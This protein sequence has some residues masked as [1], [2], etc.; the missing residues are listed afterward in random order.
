MQEKDIANTFAKLEEHLFFARNQY[1]RRA[2]ICSPLRA[3]TALG[4]YKNMYKA[5]EYMLYTAR[6]MKYTPYAPH[7][8]IPMLLNDIFPEERVLALDFGLRLLELCETLFVCGG[9]ISDGMKGEISHAAKKG[10][11]ILVFNAHVC[12]E[13]KQI[14]SD[15]GG[16]AQSVQLNVSHSY[17]GNPVSRTGR[18]KVSG[19][20]WGG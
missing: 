19:H 1:H 5:R 10:L 13:V 15:A 17:L 18:G 2:Y 11:K 3:D 20:S 4:I 9:Y 8:Y 7:A 12:D 6:T 16:D 14:V